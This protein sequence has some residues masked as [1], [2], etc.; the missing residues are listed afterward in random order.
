MGIII[1]CNQCKS[2]LNYDIGDGDVIERQVDDCPVCRGG[3][4]LIECVGELNWLGW[5][6]T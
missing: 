1:L 5:R 2:I 3:L 4:K 6:E